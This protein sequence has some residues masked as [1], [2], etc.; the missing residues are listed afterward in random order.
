MNRCCLGREGVLGRVRLV[1]A[2]RPVPPG[3]DRGTG[4]QIYADHGGDLKVTA[5][6]AGRDSTHTAQLYNGPKHT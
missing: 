2:R 4:V 6:I 3:V 1:D 5:R